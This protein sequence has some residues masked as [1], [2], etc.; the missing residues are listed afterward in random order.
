MTCIVV[1]EN[2]DIDEE[3]TVGDEVLKMYGTNIY[4]E[5]G[6]VIKIRDLLYG[7]MLRSGN[8]AAITLA[9]HTMGSEEAFVSKMNEV[10]KKIGMKNTNFQNSHGLDEETQN[11]ST[12]YDMALLSRY[13][14]RNEEYRKILQTKKYQTQSSLKSYIWYN[15]M[16]L[17]NQYSYC[18]GGKNGYTPKAGKTLVSLAKKGNMT[19][20]ITSLDDSMLY[21]NHEE[22]YER[23]FSKYQ[24]YTV[25]DQNDFHGFSTFFPDKVYIKKSFQY[26]FTEEELKSVSTFLAFHPIQKNGTVG[27]ITVRLGQDTIGKI[28]LYSKEKEE[29]NL[30]FFERFKQLIF[31]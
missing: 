21:D 16:K 12:A 17:L 1:L 26:P 27:D 10:A 4:L 14:Y 15:R 30:S 13:A 31:G 19:L 22:L 18:I 8:D 11:Y 24:M 6:E 7:L 25:I 2:A 28:L 20:T 5:I 23:F 9:V 29:K 3:I